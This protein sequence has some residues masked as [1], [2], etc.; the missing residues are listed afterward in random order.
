M[1][2]QND[3]QDRPPLTPMEKIAVVGFAAPLLQQAADAATALFSRS[4]QR[5][6]STETRER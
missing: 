5:P 3:G 1:T 6:P 2:E 4:E